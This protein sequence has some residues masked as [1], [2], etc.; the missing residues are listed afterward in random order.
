M[1]FFQLL[2]YIQQL[3]KREKMA[4]EANSLLV[5]DHNSISTYCTLF[6]ERSA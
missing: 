4:H 5:S 2:V 6:Y 1:F 3:R